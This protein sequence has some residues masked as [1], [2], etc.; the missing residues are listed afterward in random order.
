MEDLGQVIVRPADASIVLA[1]RKT[2]RI[3][4]VLIGVYCFSRIITI[5]FD[6]DRASIAGLFNPVV[7]AIFFSGFVPGSLWQ[8]LVVSF[9]GYALPVIS[10][11]AVAVR[12]R[13]A[14]HEK[15][16]VRGVAGETILAMTSRLTVW[17]GAALMIL[18][19]LGQTNAFNSIPA[20]VTWAAGLTLGLLEQWFQAA[21]VAKAHGISGRNG[22]VPAIITSV[23]TILVAGAIFLLTGVIR[24]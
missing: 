6:P 21:C 17:C 23:V 2:T 5:A 13:V 22:L 9:A 7:L 20:I 16:P 19:P 18:V 4:M 15:V 14:A 24:S 12:I 8:S 1:N 3:V 11:A 10:A